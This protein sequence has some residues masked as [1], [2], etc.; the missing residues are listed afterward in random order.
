LSSSHHLKESHAEG[1]HIDVTC[2]FQAGRRLHAY[3]RKCTHK[4]MNTCMYGH[5]RAASL[6]AMVEPSFVDSVIVPYSKIPNAGTIVTAHAHSFTDSAGDPVTLPRPP[7]LVCHLS[8]DTCKRIKT[9]IWKGS[10]I[11][12]CD[13]VAL[14]WAAWQARSESCSHVT[15]IWVRLTD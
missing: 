15:C 9:H 7:Q 5:I 13:S 3:K 10:V 12:I 14:V 6:R 2:H 4:C 1:V 11:D 8:N